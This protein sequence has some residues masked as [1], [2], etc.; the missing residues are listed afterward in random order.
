M[1]DVLGYNNFCSACD[2]NA[3]YNAYRMAIEIVKS[4]GVS[5]DDGKER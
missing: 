4:G 3:S 1:C 2:G 5:V